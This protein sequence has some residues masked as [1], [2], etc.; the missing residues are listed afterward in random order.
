[1]RLSIYDWIGFPSDCPLPAPLLDRLFTLPP[2]GEVGMSNIEWMTLHYA[3][4]LAARLDVLASH[5]S[6][7]QFAEHL[8]EDLHMRRFLRRVVQRLESA[9]SQDPDVVWNPDPFLELAKKARSLQEWH[10]GQLMR[11]DTG[12][13]ASAAITVIGP[14]DTIPSQEGP[15]LSELF[16]EYGSEVGLN[17][18]SYA[19]PFDALELMVR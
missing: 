4:S 8:R 13:A 15:S 2:G 11:W 10:R 1:M 17:C 18:F 3:Y 5:P 14:G 12:G 19:E 7:C 9:A 6:I 16:V